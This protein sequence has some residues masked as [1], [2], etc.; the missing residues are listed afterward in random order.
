M[1]VDEQQADVDQRDRQHHAVERHRAE[2]LAE[3][4]LEVG[5]RRGQQQL[6]RA[7]SL[8]LRV[9]AHRDHRHAGTGSGS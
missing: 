8:L 9:G 5:E 7:R 3:D 2:E 1:A 4:D 6:D